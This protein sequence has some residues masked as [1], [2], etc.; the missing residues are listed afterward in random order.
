MKHSV[1]SVESVIA[2]SPTPSQDSISSMT[3]A[4]EN[5]S[6]E[7]RMNEEEICGHPTTGSPELPGM[8]FAQVC[9]LSAAF[10]HVFVAALMFTDHMAMNALLCCT[11]ICKDRSIYNV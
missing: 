2:S 6:Q 3:V 7:P 4:A 8:S 1:S 9:T 10:P 11:Y 5:M